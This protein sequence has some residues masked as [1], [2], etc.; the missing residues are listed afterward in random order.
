MSHLRNLRLQKNIFCDLKSH[1][2][3]PSPSPSLPLPFPQYLPPSL[4][5]N[6]VS[7]LIFLSR[8]PEEEKVDAVRKRKSK[9]G[10]GVPRKLK[11]RFLAVAATAAA[12]VE[13]ECFKSGSA[14]EKV[15]QRRFI[16]DD[17]RTTEKS[18]R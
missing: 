8:K 1:S 14:V 12:Q 13:F 4:V 3:S 2:F 16:D 11:D 5:N 9:K 7:H 18:K 6:H 17:E 10:I 15:L